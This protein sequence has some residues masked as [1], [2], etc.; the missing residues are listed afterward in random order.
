MLKFI[1]RDFL[2]SIKIYW[3]SIKTIFR[4]ITSGSIILVYTI[5]KVA[6]K[7][8]YDS[9]REKNSNVFH[10][11]YLRRN[12]RSFEIRLMNYFIKN[13]KKEIKVIVS[14]RNPINRNF[15]SFF[16]IYKEV[17]GTSVNTVKLQKLQ[18][19]FL[20][21]FP[22]Y[23]ILNWHLNE[24][25]EAFGVDIF[26]TPFVGDHKSFKKENVSILVLK[27]E[28][29]DEIKNVIIGRHLD[30]PNFELKNSNI[31]RDKEI[32]EKYLAFKNT[33]SYPKNMLTKFKDSELNRALNYFD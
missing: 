7:S 23:E 33:T 24:L 6:S 1:L 4:L 19:Q 5:G 30:I 26:E 31:S 27:S 17:Y 21:D 13:T 18:E 28:I 2:R 14:Y 12:H 9:I 25:Q 3:Y 32:A 10:V 29:I 20:S 11:H 15:S 8:I 16:E 22:H